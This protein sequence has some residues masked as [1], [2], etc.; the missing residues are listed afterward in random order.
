M[1]GNLVLRKGGNPG[2][3]AD[4]RSNSTNAVRIALLVVVMM[5]LVPSLG[6]L[7]ASPVVGGSQAIAYSAMAAPVA[8]AGV[9][10]T[11]WFGNVT[12]LNASLTTSDLYRPALLDYNWTIEDNGT[13]YVLGNG[14]PVSQYTFSTTGI[15]TINLTVTDPLNQTSTDQV[16]VTIVPKVELGSNRRLD[17]GTESL[18]IVFNGSASKPSG[19]IVSYLWNVT[20][21]DTSYATGTNAPLQYTFSRAGNYTVYLTVTDSHGFS[22]TQSIFVNVIP[23]PSFFMKHWVFTF[24]GIPIMLVAAYILIG[25]WRKGSGLITKTDVEKAKLQ[26]KTFKKDW[27]IFKANRLGFAGLLVLVM[28]VAMAFLAPVLSTVPNPDKHEEP[29]VDNPDPSLPPILCPRL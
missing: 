2:P 1:I 15:Y 11:D 16:V 27:R 5:T 7:N 4:S 13:H 29:R 22:N 20:K 9:D 10:H 19:L 8:N 18:T 3:I 21:G 14:S 25:R 26:W 28:F 17:M 23:K 6:F 24:I 12:R